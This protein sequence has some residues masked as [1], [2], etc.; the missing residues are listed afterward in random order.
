ARPEFPFTRRLDR[1][2]V[3][4]EGRIERAD[5]VNVADS[6]VRV[7][8]TFEQHG[9]LDF[10]THR[11]RRVI[12]SLFSDNARRRHAIT[13][14]ERATTGAAA[15]SLAQAGSPTRPDSRAHTGSR[16]A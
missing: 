6:A 4:A 9:A 12:R 11:V 15:V 14:T 7:H 3:E 5:H 10:G 16:P 2:L 8:D 1:L 13:R